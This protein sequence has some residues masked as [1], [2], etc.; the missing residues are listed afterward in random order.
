MFDSWPAILCL[1]MLKPPIGLTYPIMGLVR[2][3]GKEVLMLLLR[4][5]ITGL[6]SQLDSE[7]QGMVLK[8]IQPL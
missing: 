8:I 1:L 5:P 3:F 6:N 4:L 7:Y 2:N